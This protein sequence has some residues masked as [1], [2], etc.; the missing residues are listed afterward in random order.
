[1]NVIDLFCGAGGFSLGFERAGFTVIAAYDSW[2]KA[3]SVYRRNFSHPA[4]TVNLSNVETV[5]P[6]MLA[7]HPDIII[8]G[9]P[10][11]DFSHA[12]NRCEGERANLTQSFAHIVSSIRPLCFVMENVARAQSSTAYLGA[13]DSLKASGYGLS[14]HVLDASLCGVPQKRKRFFCVGILGEQDGFLGRVI[15]AGFSNMPMTPRVYLGNELGIEHYYR[16]PRTYSRRA[17]FSVNE[18]APTV[19][20]VN[21][22]VP[23]GYASHAGDTALPHGIRA[24]TTGERARLQTFPSTFAWSGTKTDIE[25]MIGNAVPVELGEYVGRAL[26]T[27]IAG[28]F[29]Q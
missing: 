28:K 12:G 18:P 26:M 29:A 24:L 20:G 27:Y 14:E 3:I 21:R 10:C 6:D 15:R 8:G 23:P 5:L 25:Q 17:I 4:H 22:P 16:H 1:M 13:R 11:Q 7:L 9:P 19:R 2:D